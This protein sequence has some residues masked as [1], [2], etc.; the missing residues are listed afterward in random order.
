M[1]QNNLSLKSVFIISC[2]TLFEWAEFVFYAYLSLTFSHLFFPQLSTEKGLYYVFSI[3]GMG[4]LVRPLGGVLFGYLG[5]KYGRKKSLTLS[6]GLMGV[7]TCLIGC[8][9][10]YHEVGVLAVIALVVLR[11]LQ[12]L[13]VSGEFATAG[14]YMSEM[15]MSAY[16]YLPGSLIACFSAMG[17]LF[18]AIFAYLVTLPG[19]PDFAWRIPY[20][21]GGLFALFMLYYR[22]TLPETPDFLG[23][24]ALVIKSSHIAILLKRYTRSVL[25]IA[26]FAAFICFYVYTCNVWWTTH[27][28]TTHLFSE[29]VGRLLNVLAQVAVVILTPLCA[30]FAH[31]FKAKSMIR[32]GLVGACIASIGLFYFSAHSDTV[33]TASSLFLYAL[34]D[35]FVTSVMFLYFLTLFPV[36]YRCLGQGF[37]WN[38]SVAIFGSVV[39]LIANALAA[40][41]ISVAPAL[42]VFVSAV[43]LYIFLK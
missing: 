22:R 32:F 8:L 3:F 38:I 14:I 24:A 37:S 35:A 27:V 2:G 5:D 15:H 41:H 43:M 20:W 10:T 40:T 28:I 16:P 42:G 36:R 31:H 21:A 19:M 11:L 1:K 23:S 13:S 34:S 17:M 33:L 30:M 29:K 4:L 6:L 9:P 18:A 26:L 39:L 7:S 25:V 12:G